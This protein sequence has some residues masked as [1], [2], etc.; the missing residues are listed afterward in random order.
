LGEKITEI[1]K[2][3]IKRISGYLIVALTGLSEGLLIIIQIDKTAMSKR[4]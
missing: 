1:N 4:E 2:A 3:R